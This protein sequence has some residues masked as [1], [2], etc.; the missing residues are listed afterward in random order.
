MKQNSLNIFRDNFNKTFKQSVDA[1]KSLDIALAK[2][3]AEL[4]RNQGW[5]EKVLK[6]LG[7]V[8]ITQRSPETEMYTISTYYRFHR[9]LLNDTQSF[10]PS[11]INSFEQ[12]IY[13]FGLLMNTT[14]CMTSPLPSLSMLNK[15]H[16]K[17]YLLQSWQDVSSRAQF[18][19][20]MTL[21]KI[22]APYVCI[23]GKTE[24]F[25]MFIC[26]N[27]PK[28]ISCIFVLLMLLTTQSEE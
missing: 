17:S 14:H 19:S 8:L 9:S 13:L 1:V 3:E 25:A 4:W 15:M 21:V 7:Y 6:T 23:Y 11:I 27:Y 2:R 12:L 18:I 5:V 10:N 22:I 20:S 28:Y 26:A 24:S 16:K